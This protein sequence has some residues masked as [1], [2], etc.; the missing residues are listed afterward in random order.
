[1][2]FTLGGGLLLS[3]CSGDQH[4]FTEADAGGDLDSAVADDRTVDFGDAGGDV[5]TT[6][7]TQWI[8]ETL[9]PGADG[10]LGTSDDPVIARGVSDLSKGN[11]VG[12]GFHYASP[13]TDGVWGTQDDVVDFATSLRDHGTSFDVVTSDA[14]GPD[15]KWGT[16]DDHA[17]AWKLGVWAGGR[18][19]ELKTMLPGQ[20]G[21]LGTPDD[22]PTSRSQFGYGDG[23]KEARLHESFFD[24]PS[25]TFV[26]ADF[27]WNDWGFTT[28]GAGVDGV[29]G[30]KDDDLVGRHV[31]ETVGSRTESVSWRAG[32]DGKYFTPDDVISSYAVVTCTQGVYESIL[33]RAAG[34]DGI[35][36]TADDEPVAHARYAGCGSCG[37]RPQDPADPN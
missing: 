21:V 18:V 31:N 13:G 26:W 37:A 3:A 4:P 16:A 9:G 10:I 17:S 29:L 34:P 12:S 2:Y 19:S 1:M 22:V 25:N 23:V 27:L 33:Y 11:Y 32:P 20:D 30:T 28:K 7:C 8:A 5:A 14:P 24:L 35:W 36:K 6:T 15:A